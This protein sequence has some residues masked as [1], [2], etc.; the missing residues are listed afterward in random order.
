MID[1]H[2]CVRRHDRFMGFRRR[3]PTNPAISK[4]VVNAC[5]C[6]N[7][8]ISSATFFLVVHNIMICKYLDAASRTRIVLHLHTIAVRV[9]TR[10]R[11]RMIFFVQT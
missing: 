8:G 9:R 5:V 3:E 7:T 10:N 6:N 11:A 1:D 4:R 2:Q